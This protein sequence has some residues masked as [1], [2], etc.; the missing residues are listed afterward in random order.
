MALRHSGLVVEEVQ[1]DGE[2]VQKLEDVFAN[3]YIVGAE[4]F[5]AEGCSGKLM[6]YEI[7]GR[8]K[9]NWFQFF[10]LDE[11]KSFPEIF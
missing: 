5:E 4:H 11:L 7:K 6:A 10:Q 1:V 2:V 9:L 3:T 8:E